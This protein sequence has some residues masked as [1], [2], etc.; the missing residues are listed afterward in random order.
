MTR[1]A[2]ML[3]LAALIP[4]PVRADVQGPCPDGYAYVEKEDRCVN[5]YGWCPDREGVMAYWYCPKPHHPNFQC[6]P[7]GS[8]FGPP[9]PH[10]CRKPFPPEPG[11]K[12]ERWG[13][14]HG[15]KPRRVDPPEG[16]NQ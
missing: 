7:E 6:F 10:C 5:R 11:S 1:R 15:W 13:R 3:A 16:S 2:I 12:G 8:I 4:G 9:G 14:C